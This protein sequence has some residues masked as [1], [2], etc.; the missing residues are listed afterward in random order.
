M[1]KSDKY[2]IVG[3]QFGYWTVLEEAGFIKNH[4]VFLCRCVCGKERV[5]PGASLRS[6]HTK[7]CGCKKF[8][9]RPDVKDLTGQTIGYWQVLALVERNKYGKKQYLCRCKCGKEKIVSGE[10][11][12]HGKSKSCG[13]MG[14]GRQLLETDLTGQQF[15]YWTV[16]GPSKTQNPEM[17]NRYYHCRCVCGNERDIK[18]LSLVTGQSKSCGCKSGRTEDLTGKQFGYWTVLAKADRSESRKA[19]YLC[20]CRCGTE[21][22]VEANNLKNGNSRSCGCLRLEA[23]RNRK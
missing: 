14:N 22:V 17:T 4:R 5:L 16:L 23:L 6:G 3:Q 7:S 12:R 10:S 19:R 20:R 13:C 9:N 2:N 21:K 1:P 11:L 15:G 8:E 18:A